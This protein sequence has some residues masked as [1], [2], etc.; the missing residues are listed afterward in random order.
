MASL[1]L[2]QRLLHD[3]SRE[4]VDL[5]LLYGQVDISQIG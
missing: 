3:C 2:L 1:V 5:E 4:N